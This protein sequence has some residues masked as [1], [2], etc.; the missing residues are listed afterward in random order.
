MYRTGDLA[1][2]LHDCVVE[3]IG[4]RDDQVKLRGFRIELG[5][6]ESALAA[7]DNV[8]MNAVL[9]REI[10]SG[11]KELVAYVVPK[12]TADALSLRLSL[13]AKLPAHMIPTSFVMMSELPRLANGKIDRNALAAS[14]AELR[15]TAAATNAPT[16]PAEKALAD[17]WSELL[18]VGNDAIERSDNFF[19]LGGDSLQA[20][21]VVIA[22]HRMSG[23]QLE[24][25]RMIFESL[26]QLAGGIELPELEPVV[27]A[28]PPPEARAGWLKRFLK[29]S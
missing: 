13:K 23:V 14:S 29:R 22:F 24:A 5:E 26:A 6:I 2:W 27:A 4:R 28:A 20:S 17:I 25:N 8:R 18:G 7:C 19:D 21:R 1:R 16:T 15:P 9:M 3:F 10:T 11:R 12:G